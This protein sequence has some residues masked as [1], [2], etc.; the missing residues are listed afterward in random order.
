MAHYPTITH[1]SIKMTIFVP[2]PLTISQ[3]AAILGGNKNIP[4]PK[5]LP[6]RGHPSTPPPPAVLEDKNT[7]ES[8]ADRCK[9][10]TLS[11]WNWCRV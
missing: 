2:P 1:L 10:R 8:N 9:F 4:K 7:G 5:T 6:I 3:L 11:P